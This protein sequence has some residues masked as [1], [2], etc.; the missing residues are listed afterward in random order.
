MR[1]TLRS[2][3]VIA[4]IAACGI[5]PGQLRAQ[6]FRHLGPG[7][8]RPLAT[9]PVPEP[10][11]QHQDVPRPIVGLPVG[12]PHQEPG[13]FWALREPA[14]F[15][16]DRSPP[17]LDREFVAERIVPALRAELQ[18]GDGA[19]RVPMALLALAR[20]E[21]SDALLAELQRR[22]ADED[23][24]MRSTAVFALGLTGAR[25]AVGS[26]AERTRPEH[27]VEVRTNAAW[28][29]GVLARRAEDG[30]A[31]REAAEHL[32]AIAFDGDAPERP[33]IAAL[34]GLVDAYAARP[35]ADT[36]LLDVLTDVRDLWEDDEVPVLVRCQV[37]VV[38]TAMSR[39]LPGGAGI[40]AVAAESWL[41]IVTDSG[42]APALRHAALVGVGQALE[43]TRDTAAVAAVTAL[44]DAGE[45]LVGAAA[46]AAGRIGG[47][48]ACR[49][50]LELLGSENE[51]VE[52]PWAAV[53]G[54]LLQHGRRARGG[55]PDPAI[56]ERMLD[57]LENAGPPAI[58]SLVLGL[59]LSG[60][61]AAVPGL[62]RLLA[63]NRDRDELAGSLMVAMVQLDPE[64]A[65]PEAFELL[66][67]SRRRPQRARRVS[68][69]LGR[70]GSARATDVLVDA[71]GTRHRDLSCSAAQ[72]MGIGP[73][74][75]Q[76]AAERLLTLLD[77]S[78][79][80]DWSIA[81]VSLALGRLGDPHPPGAHDELLARI[82][83]RAFPT[84]EFDVRDG[85]LA[86]W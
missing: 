21:R 65:A 5:V 20:L 26:L 31:W 24:K 66:A 41:A 67:Q 60:D 32:R 35:A 16:P 42:A 30:D 62:A 83:W 80:S 68:E 55:R 45:D 74:R 13:V 33:R 77:Q 58:D 59:A 56:Q 19:R 72:V 2:G 50:I 8:L 23:P 73:S 1:S 63:R 29:L 64:S 10:P 34:Q 28:A 86:R 6:F 48:T 57:R 38:V 49:A 39:G 54:G 22:L 11:E 70:I 75:S 27:P 53:A 44:F 52:L 40:R 82:P 85:F 84:E 47:E 37:P 7:V 76:A 43:G 14:W 69:A 3:L 25:I 9:E 61:R 51:M 15:R 12:M 17:P 71:L 46:V 81:Y 4:A 36:A 18:R 78:E 79:T